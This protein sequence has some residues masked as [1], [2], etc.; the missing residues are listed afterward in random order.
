MEGKQVLVVFHSAS[1]NTGRVAEA[2]AEALAAD[3]E[4]IREVILVKDEN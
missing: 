4:R 2:I 1:G 3:I